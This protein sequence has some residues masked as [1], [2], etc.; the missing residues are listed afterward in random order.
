MLA[1]GF[2]RREH[3]ARFQN[4]ETVRNR[5]SD[6]E[7]QVLMAI[8]KAGGSASP[9]TIGGEMGISPGYAEQICG[10]LVWHGKLFREGRRFVIRKD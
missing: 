7:Q 3:T 5:M 2:G 6:R 10:D 9:A 8:Q 1:H 4:H